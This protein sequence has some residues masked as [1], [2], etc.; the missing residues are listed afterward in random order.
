MELLTVIVVLAVIAAIVLPKFVNSSRRAKI[1]KVR[2]DLRL[3]RGAI[4]RFRNDTGAF[5]ATLADLAA[6]T[7]PDEGLEK[8][9]SQVSIRASDWH[10]PYVASIPRDPLADK[11]YFY[12]TTPPTVGWVVPG[13]SA[14]AQATAGTRH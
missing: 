11:P 6:T 13:D 3:L 2:G 14:S 1:A 9:G 10:G 12:I 7:A 5:P 4:E 8:D